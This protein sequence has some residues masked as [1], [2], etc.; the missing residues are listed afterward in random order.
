MQFT[1]ASE[2]QIH[3]DG[4][5][6]GHPFRGEIQSFVANPK[7]LGRHINQNYLRGH[8][9]GTLRTLTGT[10][11]KVPQLAAVMITRKTRKT[12]CGFV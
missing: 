8:S 12:I 11:A 4:T 6:N 2:V 1:T 5:V 9:A 7:I 10:E 3:S